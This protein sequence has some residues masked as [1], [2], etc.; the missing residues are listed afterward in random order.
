MHFKKAGTLGLGLAVLLS[1]CAASPDLMPPKV[2]D[3]FVLDLLNPLE[4]APLQP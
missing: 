3:I 2:V 1:G 4:A